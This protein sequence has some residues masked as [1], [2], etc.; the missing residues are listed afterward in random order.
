MAQAS[1]L[2]PPLNICAQEQSFVEAETRAIDT[3][4]YVAAATATAGDDT[5][6]SAMDAGECTPMLAER[7]VLRALVTRCTRLS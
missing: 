4:T 2:Y 7:G 6:S 1:S 5:F 3:K